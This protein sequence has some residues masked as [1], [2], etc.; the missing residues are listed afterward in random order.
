ML[1]ESI[2][3]DGITQPEALMAY[4]LAFERVREKISLF[5]GLSDRQQNLIFPYLNFAT[6]SRGDCLFKQG[7]LPG[8]IYI[9]LTGEVQLQVARQDGS[10]V[11]VSYLPGDC[12]G[13]TSVIG[14]QPQLGTAIVAEDAQVIVLSRSCLLEVSAYDP[15][16]FGILM[17]NVAREISRRFHSTLMADQGCDVLPVMRA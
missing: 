9:V 2:E 3:M 11:A 7:Q 8:N 16:M 14:I 10:A 5:G 13:E 12:F 1:A 4:P 6:F 17:M 15:E